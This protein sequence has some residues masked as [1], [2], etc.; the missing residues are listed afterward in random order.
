MH[1]LTTS[2]REGLATMLGERKRVMYDEIRAGLAGMRGEAYEDLLTG[3]SD[4][5]DATLARLITD[6]ANA[7]VAR[8]ATELKDILAA[9]ARLAAGTYGICLDCDEPVPY[10]RLA[11]FPTAKRC[12]RCQKTHEARNGPAARR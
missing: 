11:A 2:E 5:G 7:D 4:A 3:T 12:I 8:D 10:A 6:V 9:E 1:E